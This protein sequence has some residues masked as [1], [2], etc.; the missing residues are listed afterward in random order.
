[1]RFTKKPLPEKFRQDFEELYYEMM[2]NAE[3]EENIAKNSNSPFWI[4]TKEDR[5][6]KQHI[7]NNLFNLYNGFRGEVWAKM[8][9]GYTKSSKLQN[10]INWDP[11]FLN[12]SSEVALCEFIHGEINFDKLHKGCY[13]PACKKEV[14]KLKAM[15]YKKAIK[16]CKIA[17]TKA[18]VA[19]EDFG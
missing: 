1:M 14:K 19:W 5:I 9:P 3:C 17:C 13:M 11:F 15:G 7:L 4:E 8:N 2:A 10:N 16:I 18:G 12:S 6:G